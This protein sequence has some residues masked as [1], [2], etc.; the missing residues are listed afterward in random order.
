[1]CWTMRRGARPG[2]SGKHTR[3][4]LLK[5]HGPMVVVELA[6][7]VV[8]VVML[9]VLVLRLVLV[10]VVASVGHSL[11][12][13]PNGL[14]DAAEVSGHRNLRPPQKDRLEDFIR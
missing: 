12:Y 5:H 2:A 9:A 4:Q 3:C 8:V 6:M 10:V 13:L 11:H 7:V 14:S 1:M